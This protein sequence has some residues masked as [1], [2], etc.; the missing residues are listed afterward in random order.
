MHCFPFLHCIARALAERSRS[1]PQALRNLAHDGRCCPLS[2]LREPPPKRV[3]PLRLCLLPAPR[4]FVF[5]YFRRFLPARMVARDQTYFSG[6]GTVH[7]GAGWLGSPVY[8][9]GLGSGA[10]RPP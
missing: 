8:E 10:E 4:R 6:R 5:I 3:Q 1:A 2:H 7:A 9:I